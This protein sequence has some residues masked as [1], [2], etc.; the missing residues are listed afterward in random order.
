MIPRPHKGTRDWP[1]TGCHLLHCS[2]VM[3]AETVGLRCQTM[4]RVAPT[5]NRDEAT[6]SGSRRGVP[7]LRFSGLPA[8]VQRR[9][10]GAGVSSA[11]QSRR[12]LNRVSERQMEVPR[13]GRCSAFQSV[14]PA[15]QSR[16]G[17]NRISERQMEVSRPGRCSAFQ[18]VP[19]N[20]PSGPP[21]A[22]QRRTIGVVARRRAGKGCDH[23]DG[24]PAASLRAGTGARERA[25]RGCPPRSFSERESS[26]SVLVEKNSKDGTP[27]AA[28]YSRRLRG[29]SGTPR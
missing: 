27:G 5:A 26:G 11:H 2:A 25:P 23:A 19:E 18:G 3:P 1:R 8:A 12:G 7:Q 20:R 13:R 28:P 15:H 22:V 4:L 9:V 21:L 10:V 24:T 14:S 16:N 29:G 17:M 6:T